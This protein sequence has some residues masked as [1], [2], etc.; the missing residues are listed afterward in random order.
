MKRL[1]SLRPVA[2]A[3]ALFMLFS[4]LA[5]QAEITS[6]ASAINKAGR[7]R[8]L[9]QSM[10]K[11]YCLMGQEISKE[12]SSGRLQQSV[13]LFDLQL[14]ELKGYA[15]NSETREALAKVET[16]WRP[17]KA[18]VLAPASRDKVGALMMADDEL[19]P[20]THRVVLL[21]QDVSGTPQDRL[22][23]ISG[24]QRML[25]QRLTKLYMLRSWSFDNAQIRS[26]LDQ[27]RNEFKGA[28]TELEN[29]PENNATI[30]HTLSEARRQWSLFE[31]GLNRSGTELVPLVVSMTSDKLLATMN[32]LTTMYELL[33]V[34]TASS[35]RP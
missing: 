7:Q 21:L 6:L 24:R 3:A 26:D 18:L 14:D 27:A 11:D 9:T 28:L 2:V 8:M 13:A 34:T 23:N 20:A 15:P 25:S 17:F 35:K 22:V 30:R 16:L 10:V 19:L 5:A 12:Q 33:P 29:A 32:E 1:I 31:H 4:S